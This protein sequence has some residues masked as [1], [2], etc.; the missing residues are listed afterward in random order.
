M[1][2]QVDAVDTAPPMPIPTGPRDY[3]A[4]RQWEDWQKQ[5]GIWRYRAS[6]QREVQR[7]DKVGTMTDRAVGDLEPGQR[8]ADE[9][10]RPLTAA[11]ELAQDEAL[12]ALGDK[13]L[14]KVGVDVTN[15]LLLDAAVIAVT[16]VLAALSRTRPAQLQGV[17]LDLGGKIM[18]EVERRAWA[19]AEKDAKKQSLAPDEKPAPALYSLMVQ[20]NK[21]VDTRVFEKWSKKAAQYTAGEWSSEDRKRVGLKFIS[22]LIE[23]DGWFEVKSE[24][25]KGK[26]MLMFQL[27]DTARAWIAQRHAQNELSRPFMLPMICE[28]QD[29]EYLPEAPQ[30]DP[31]EVSCDDE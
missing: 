15:V 11:I 31:D 21:R 13:D 23:V 17:A 16:T 26:T 3:E 7:G 14:K 4:Q 20:R 24:M 12:A 1:D 5:R 30:A 9:I 27:T 19:Q 18:A 29:Y 2:T 6:L 28:P 8:I 25:S 10:I 22:L